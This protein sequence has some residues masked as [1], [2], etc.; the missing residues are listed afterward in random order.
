MMK[1]SKGM[2]IFNCVFVKFLIVIFIGLIDHFV[3]S[4]YSKYMIHCGNCRGRN[5]RR[6]SGGGTAN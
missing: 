4:Y 3:H 5:M 2:L 1:K 6:G